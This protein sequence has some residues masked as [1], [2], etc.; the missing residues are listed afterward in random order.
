[1]TQRMLFRLTVYVWSLLH[2]SQLKIY[3]LIGADKSVVDESKDE[4]KEEF[5]AP[6]EERNDFTLFEEV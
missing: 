2:V 4:N 5:V 3:L 1:M 6:N